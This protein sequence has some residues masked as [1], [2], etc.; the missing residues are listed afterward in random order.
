MNRLPDALRGKVRRT[1]WKLYATRALR[2]LWPLWVVA[3][4]VGA[5]WVLG[6]FDLLEG[7]AR[8]G[9]LAAAGVA[10]A[11]ALALGL[12][13]LSWPTQDEALRALDDGLAHRAASMMDDDLAVGRE[14]DHAAKLWRAHRERLAREAEAATVP[15]VNTRLSAYDTW[16]LRYAALFLFVIAALWSRVGGRETVER[17]MLDLPEPGPQIAALEP[18]LEA[19]VAPPPYTGEAPIYLNEREGAVAVP[20]GSVLTLRASGVEEAPLAGEEPF[21]EDAKGIFGLT[22]TLTEDG[23]LDVTYRGGSLGAWALTVTPDRAPEIGVTEAPDATPERALGFAFAAEDDYGVTAA[24]AV[25]TA[26]RSGMD[27][28]PEELDAPIELTLTPPPPTTDGEVVEQ[29]VEHDLAEHPWVGSPV[30]MVLHAEDAAGQTAQSEPVSFVLPGRIFTE[31]MAKALIEQ[32]RD[33]AW[34]IRGAWDALDMIEAFTDYPDDYFTDPTAFLATSTAKKRLTYAVEE[35]RTVEERGDVLELLWKAALRLEEGD[36]DNALEQLQAAQ[37]RLQDALDRGASDEEIERLMDELRQAMNDYLDEMVRQAQRDQQNGQQPD[38]EMSEN[39]QTLTRQDLEEMLRQL[40]EAAKN[41]SREQAEQMLS[42]LGQMLENLQQGRTAQGQGQ[43]SQQEQAL[44]EMMRRQQELADETF[45]DLQN[46]QN[47]QRQNRPG[48]QGEGEQGQ[49]QGQQPGQNGQQGQGQQRGQGQGRGEGN[50]ELGQGGQG[51]QQGQ[52]RPGRGGREDSRRGERGGG[53]S[54]RSQQ[55]GLRDELDD[56][57]GGMEGSGARDPL[58]DAEREMGEARDRLG[59]G[60]LNDALDRQSRAL[61]RLREGAQALA[62]E[63]A[64]DAQQGEGSQ[65]GRQA[66]EEGGN[67]AEMDPFGRTSRTYGPDDGEGVDVPGERA[68]NRALEIQ[69]EIRR[70][71]SERERST[72]ERDYLDRLQRRF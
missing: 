54:L 14:D 30:T 53:G 23:E 1:R 48:Q 66:G 37:R 72:E 18:A 44:Q 65:D 70:R 6:V 71:Q 27:D 25:I 55:E 10:L 60:D 49:Q 13:R 26:D 39:A 9:A 33:I 36:L 43:G 31:P 2:A 67:A 58:G 57:L 21:A 16:G 3:A 41:G 51:G 59:S 12:W 7:G 45:R 32:R 68:R 29:V 38:G 22:R 11:S 5:L 42:M 64:R 46:G 61:D 8:T 63:A 4:L 50:R 28:A 47:G 56:L 40:E 35:E 20:T 19:W 62:E 34:D 52:S 17:W 15:P 69:R 24:R